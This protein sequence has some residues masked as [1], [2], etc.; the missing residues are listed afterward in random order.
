MFLP[1]FRPVAL[2]NRSSPPCGVRLDFY[3]T[4]RFVAGRLFLL[5][6]ITW[7]SGIPEV[8]LNWRLD[9]SPMMFQRPYWCDLTLQTDRQNSE[10]QKF[11]KKTNSEKSWLVYTELGK[12][13]EKKT[14]EKAVRLTAWVD[15]S[16][17]PQ[18]VRYYVQF[19]WQ[20][21]ILGVILPFYKRQK[22]VK[23][24]TNRF[25]QS[26]QPDCL[27]PVFL[28]PFLHLISKILVWWPNP[29][30]SFSTFVQN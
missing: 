7:Y 18:A 28:E 1:T 19:S 9:P 14:W 12:G 29:S 26:S 15:P 27:F 20:V 30:I 21:A 8:S 10:E 17:S 13:S 4:F 5:F 3:K 24:F 11:H 6:S 22:W 25:G 2:H 16:P 23:I